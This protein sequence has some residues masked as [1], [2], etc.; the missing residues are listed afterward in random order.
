MPQEKEE[1][2]FTDYPKKRK[3]LIQQIA[4]REEEK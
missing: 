3:K 1:N 2:N 4:P